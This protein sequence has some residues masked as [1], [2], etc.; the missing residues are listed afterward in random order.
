MDTE[1][2]DLYEY[3][4]RFRVKN[5]PG[6][7]HFAISVQPGMIELA[8]GLFEEALHW[9]AGVGHMADK[10][11]VSTLVFHRSGMFVRLTE[12]KH[13]MAARDLSYQAIP[14]GFAWFARD[15]IKIWTSLKG[16]HPKWTVDKEGLMVY[17]EIEE[18]SPVTL[19]LD[20][21]YIPCPKCKGLGNVSRGDGDAKNSYEC[22]TCR[23]TGMKEDEEEI[24]SDDAL[25]TLGE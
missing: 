20:S 10:W 9:D 6:I 21:I 19:R 11:G 7:T 3:L 13:E 4:E 18:I 16:L 2:F 23:G 5:S 25:Y 1:S 14:V 12:S 22:G 15:H 8:V 24:K 17:L